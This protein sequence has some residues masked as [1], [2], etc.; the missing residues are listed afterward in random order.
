MNLLC[1]WL[2]VGNNRL[3]LNS[4]FCSERNFSSFLSSRCVMEP[5][6][7]L[8]VVVSS[9]KQL[10]PLERWIPEENCCWRAVISWSLRKFEKYFHANRISLSGVRSVESCCRKISR[11]IFFQKRMI[12][13][14]W[15][16]RGS[17]HWHMLTEEAVSAISISALWKGNSWRIDVSGCYSKIAAQWNE[18]FGWAQNGKLMRGCWVIIDLAEGGI[19]VLMTFVSGVS[20]KDLYNDDN[21]SRKVSIWAFWYF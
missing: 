17:L 21:M 15:R 11:K 12:P 20:S 9:K 16:G 4:L 2:L 1:T 13:F 3:S 5:E 19:W 8:V 18:L 10:R 14:L 7:D 6:S